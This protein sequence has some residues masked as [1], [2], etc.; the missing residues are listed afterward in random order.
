MS[1]IEKTRTRA[2]KIVE[3]CCKNKPKE[4]C[5]KRFEFTIYGCVSLAY[6]PGYSDNAK[7]MELFYQIVDEIESEL[8]IQV[9]AHADYTLLF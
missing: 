5:P 9:V 2:R 8:K 7:I 4:I 6:L 3:Q 1:A